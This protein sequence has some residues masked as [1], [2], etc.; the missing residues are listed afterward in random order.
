MTSLVS[1]QE[2]KD[3]VFS[4]QPEDDGAIDLKMQLAT[5]IV[6][7][8]VG[9]NDPVTGVARTWTEATVPDPVK[10]AILELV[11]NM[12]AH[13]G[14][15]EQAASIDDLPPRVRAWLNRYREPVVA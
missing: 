11:A 14:D 10:A 5:G 15:E 6:L 1:L 7:D 12:W 2:A 4:T 8:Y 3:Q 9:L 13:R